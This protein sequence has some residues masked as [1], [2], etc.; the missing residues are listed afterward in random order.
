MPPLADRLRE[1]A[2]D[3]W[4]LRVS[5]IT[6]DDARAL[7]ALLDAAKAILDWHD[8]MMRDRGRPAFLDHFPDAPARAAIAALETSP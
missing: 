6:R 3:D 1:L 7:V 2:A 8:T 5:D 4:F